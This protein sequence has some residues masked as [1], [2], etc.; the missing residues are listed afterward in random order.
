LLLCFNALLD[1][2]IC[3]WGAFLPLV[4]LFA[5]GLA[6]AFFC[7]VADWIAVL[8]RASNLASLASSGGEVQTLWV[9]RE[10]LRRVA[11]GD[12]ETAKR[13]VEIDEELVQAQG[14]KPRHTGRAQTVAN[15]AAGA[16][17]GLSIALL[18]TGT[19]DAVSSPSY[20]AAMCASELAQHVDKRT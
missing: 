14:T 3:N 18:A 6:S 10:T 15:A 2:R 20:R 8:F 9:E 12:Q 5:F 11:A 7:V 13:L 1:N 4:N 17:I 16:F 19:I